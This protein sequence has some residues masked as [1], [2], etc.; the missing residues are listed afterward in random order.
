MSAL[1]AA[2]PSRVTEITL[3][4]DPMMVQS[5]SETQRKAPWILGEGSVSMTYDRQLLESLGIAFDE[6][7]E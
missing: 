6:G 1:T 2:D 5:G 7:K 3:I 4:T